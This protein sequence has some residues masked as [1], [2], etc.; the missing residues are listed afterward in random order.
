MS[1][2]ICHLTLYLCFVT[3]VTTTDSDICCALWWQMSLSR[4]LRKWSDCDSDSKICPSLE[5]YFD[6]SRLAPALAVRGYHLAVVYLSLVARW[7][8]PG[9]QADQLYGSLVPGYFATGRHCR[10]FRPPKMVGA[11]YGYADALP[12]PDLYSSLLAEFTNRFS[13]WY[14]AEGYEL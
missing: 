11:D 12:V 9:H 4:F 1:G 8:A 5:T 7:S 14:A 2:D 6:Q 3:N 10:Y 13:Q